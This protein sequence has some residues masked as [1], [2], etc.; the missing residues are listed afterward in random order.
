MVGLFC[1]LIYAHFAKSPVVP[2]NEVVVVDKGDA[3]TYPLNSF[4]LMQLAIRI[5]NT[6]SKSELPE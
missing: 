1:C 3:G 2:F 4:F 6:Y 5:K